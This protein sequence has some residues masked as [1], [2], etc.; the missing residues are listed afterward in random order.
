MAA[1][2]ITGGESVSGTP[3]AVARTVWSC[4]IVN[5][6]EYLMSR[7]TKL[8]EWFVYYRDQGVSVGIKAALLH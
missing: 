3:C 6:A 2:P 8:I 5:G 4:T 7:V 1:P